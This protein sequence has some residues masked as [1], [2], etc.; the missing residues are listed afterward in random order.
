MYYF[1]K[2]DD[3]DSETGHVLIFWMCHQVQDHSDDAIGHWREGSKI[4]WDYYN[5]DNGAFP[6]TSLGEFITH[7][8]K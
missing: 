8:N 7:F 5:N 3:R 4:G 1:N 6:C 2:E